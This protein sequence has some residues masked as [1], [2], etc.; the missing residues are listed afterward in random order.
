MSAVKG[1]LLLAFAL[2]VLLAGAA[3]GGAHVAMVMHYV[4]V[5]I[6]WSTASVVVFALLALSTV[7]KAVAK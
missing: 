2:V 5:E 4:G 6:T 7:M 3:V 1:V